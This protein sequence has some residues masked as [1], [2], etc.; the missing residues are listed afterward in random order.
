M[1]Q[2]RPRSPQDAPP[3]VP[4]R[5]QLHVVSKQ[6]IGHAW[7]R[8]DGAHRWQNKSPA[9]RATSEATC[10]RN[11]TGGPARF[12]IFILD[13]VIYRSNRTRRTAALDLWIVLA[14]VL[15]LVKLLKEMIS[16]GSGE[17]THRTQQTFTQP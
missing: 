1:Q 14:I 4:L 13:L 10:V 5:S 6:L 7:Q 17:R 11:A 8:V 12:R 3:Q 16:N 15:E 2:L 9:S